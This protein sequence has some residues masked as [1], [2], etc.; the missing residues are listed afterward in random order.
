MGS[1]GNIT[2]WKTS[3]IAQA[4]FRQSTVYPCHHT[5]RKR[6]WPGDQGR[7]PNYSCTLVAQPASKDTSNTCLLSGSLAPASHIKTI[8][9]KCKRR[10]FCPIM[11]RIP[12]SSPISALLPAWAFGTQS[13]YTQSRLLYAFD[14]CNTLL[15]VAA[16]HRDGSFQLERGITNLKQREGSREHCRFWGMGVHQLRGW[17]LVAFSPGLGCNVVSKAH[18]L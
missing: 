1:C 7:H 14:R 6:P 15:P 3:H 8:P 12:H 13:I 5:Q 18:V 9:Q 16:A 2:T 4:R 11:A 17:L 10:W